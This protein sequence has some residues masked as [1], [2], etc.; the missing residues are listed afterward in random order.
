MAE[1]ISLADLHQHTIYSPDI[2]TIKFLGVKAIIDS[3]PL[4][5]PRDRFKTNRKFLEEEFKKN[6]LK[7]NF[8]VPFTDHNTPRANFLF[9]KDRPDLKKHI[10]PSYEATCRFED[11]FLEA[12]RVVHINT[13][14]L[15]EEDF[16]KLQ[17]KQGNLAE[18]IDVCKDLNLVYQMN[19]T[20]WP[21]DY[22]EYNRQQ[23]EYYFKTFDFPLVE[24]INGMR[25]PAINVT[26]REIM[27][28][29][30]E[31]LGRKWV[32]TAGSDDHTYYAG[33]TWTSVEYS[34]TKEEFLENLRKGNNVNIGGEEG[35]PA[36]TVGMVWDYLY[37]RMNQ[38]LQDYI[39]EKTMKFVGSLDKTNAGVY[40]LLA[41]RILKEWKAMYTQ[42]DNIR[43][44]YGLTPLT[45]AYKDFDKRPF[46]PREIKVRD[47]P[48]IHSLD[49]LEKWDHET[50]IFFTDVPVAHHSG[51]GMW[52]NKMVDHIGK[53]GPYTVIIAPATEHSPKGYEIIDANKYTKIIKIRPSIKLFPTSENIQKDFYIDPTVYLGITLSKQEHSSRSVKKLLSSRKNREVKPYSLTHAIL[54][55]LIDKEA[56]GRPIAGVLVQDG[57][58]AKLGYGE[59]KGY[60]DIPKTEVFVTNIAGFATERLKRLYKRQGKIPDEVM[61]YVPVDSFLNEV[62]NPFKHMMWGSTISFLN[63][64]ELVLAPPAM[65][66]LLEESGVTTDVN[67]FSRGVE[68]EKFKS[69]KV[70]GKKLKVLYAGR[71]SDADHNIYEIAEIIKDVDNLD[72]VIAG[73]GP[74]EE[75]FASIMPESTLFLGRISHD[76]VAEEMG[77]ADL[78][79]VASTQH[80]HGNVYYEAISSG[81]IVLARESRA[82]NEVVGGKTLDFL[83]IYHTVEEARK[84][85]IEMKDN[86]DT[87]MAYQK[88]AREYASKHFND[89]DTVFGKQMFEA[90]LE[91]R[92]KFKP[93]L[94]T[95]GLLRNIWQKA[96]EKRKS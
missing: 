61:E 16:P 57:P 42:S 36:K 41:A 25:D 52:L 4:E 89:W 58:F 27:D 32:I 56:V 20:L 18:F 51:V 84:F 21:P 68:T 28:I 66:P 6:N 94:T 54:R 76:D 53:N 60:L 72:I 33:T 67:I 85:L 82:S 23:L 78:V 31:K 75:E 71:L 14:G 91:N 64:C 79:I 45:E 74:D 65:V 10:I 81:A 73:D 22:Q 77:V 1:R 30:S 88:Q 44:E 26:I 24:G 5:S 55:T 62:L 63:K 70:K 46:R 12:E 50:I 19:H 17:K 7:G 43:R 3:T 86:K 48:K 40:T 87:V 59:C 2:I 9:M 69:N 29:L 83:K 47:E 49:S 90:I 15:A 92:K 8:F 93:N 96:Q 39:V 95:T 38:E 35:A 37:A 34:E 80:T 13:Y 11:P